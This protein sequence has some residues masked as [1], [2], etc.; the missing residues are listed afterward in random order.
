VRRLTSHGSG[1]DVVFKA[2]CPVVLMPPPTDSVADVL[3]TGGL[4]AVPDPV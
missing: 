3:P 1:G 4:T 2:P